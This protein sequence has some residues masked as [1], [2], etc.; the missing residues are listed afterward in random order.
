MG[1]T[2]KTA[3]FMTM[4]IREAM[5]AVGYEPLG[6]QWR[7]VEGDETYIGGKKENRAYAKVAPPKQSVMALV[8]RGGAVRSFHV[9]HVNAANLHPI[10]A[11]HAHPD[12][13][14]MTDEH[15]VYVGIG[16]DFREHGTIKH[17][18]EEYVLG[19]VHTNTVEGYFSILK[20]GIYGIHHHVSEAHLHRY[21]AEFDFRYS[22]RMKLGFDDETRANLILEGG[23]GPSPDLS[24]DWWNRAS[25]AYRLAKLP[26]DHVWRRGSLIA[27]PRQLGLW[28]L[29][30]DDRDAVWQGFEAVG[31]EEVRKRLGAHQYGEQ[32][33]HLAENWLAHRDAL[34]ASEDR[35]KAIAAADEANALARNANEL[36]SSANKLARSANTTAE[37]AAASARLTADAARNSNMIAT[38]ALIAAIIASAVSILG[39]FLKH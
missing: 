14:F 1:V 27:D 13:R 39:I 19:D 30:S 21:L 18:Q 33:A 15:Q 11:K 38:L 17:K 26:R 7:V 4:R 8:E 12:S 2:L 29:M 20:R 37:S 32:R 3:W 36:A 28:R 24:T 5:K 34:E 16:W 23:M 22:H 35:R 25:G 10:I 9:P 31:P 6:G